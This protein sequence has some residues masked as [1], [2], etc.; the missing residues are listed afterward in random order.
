M[1]IRFFV[2]LL[3]FGF[4][5]AGY[6]QENPVT[7]T[8]TSKK[9]NAQT[10]E[11]KASAKLEDGW[12]IYSQTTPDGGPVPTSISFIRNPMVSL[13]GPTKEAGKLEQHF[14]QLFG[15][16]VKQ[17]SERVDFIQNVVLKAAVKTSI[18]GSV[19]FMVC[20]EHECMPPTSKRFTVELR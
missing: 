13:S 1:K 3:L 15:V 20:N 17:Y 11:I 18:S 5:S 7:W 4:V 12:H 6:A 14:E 8:F 9:L 2:A 10:Y 19:E 16:V